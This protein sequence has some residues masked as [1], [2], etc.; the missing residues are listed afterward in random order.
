MTEGLG[1]K[2]M[3]FHSSSNCI[4]EGEYSKQEERVA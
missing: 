4:S 1:K 3:F 2:L